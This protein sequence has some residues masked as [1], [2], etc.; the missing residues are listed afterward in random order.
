MENVTSDSLER[1]SDTPY[2]SLPNA[3]AVFWQKSICVSESGAFGTAQAILYPCSSFRYRTH[4]SVFAHFLI[5]THCREPASVL[6]RD[7]FLG[8]VDITW[9][10]SRNP[11]ASML[12]STAFIFP[13]SLI[14]SSKMHTVLVL[15]LT[16]EA[17]FSLL[18]SFILGARNLRASCTFL[19]IMWPSI[20]AEPECVGWNRILTASLRFAHVQLPCLRFRNTISWFCSYVSM[21]T[22][23]RKY[24]LETIA[25][26][27]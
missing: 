26:I 11:K 19:H 6:I 23:V 14:F 2:P 16:T 15:A 8:G 1:L 13:L 12:R 10:T 25:I 20:W 17:I 27:F 21:A 5:L 24:K 4:S 18:A 9:W 22:A 7:S 3:N